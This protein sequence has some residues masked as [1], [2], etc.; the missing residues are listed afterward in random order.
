MAIGIGRMLGFTFP[1]N[2]NQPYTATSITDSGGNGILRC[3]NGFGIMSIF[4]WAETVNM[5]I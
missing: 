3:L 2:F 1:I 4:L 5:Y